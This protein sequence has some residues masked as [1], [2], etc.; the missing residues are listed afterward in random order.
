MWSSFFEQ[1]V[2]HTGGSAD[3]NSFLDAEDASRC[4]VTVRFGSPWFGK[5]G[6]F[7]GA[8]E[9]RSFH[10]RR[11]RHV[12]VTADAGTTHL[13]TVAS[14]AQV[15]SQLVHC[16]SHSDSSFILHSDGADAHDFQNA[17]LPP[18][19]VSLLPSR[20]ECLSCPLRALMFLLLLFCG[21]IGAVGRNSTLQYRMTVR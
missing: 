1:R 20:F 11:G 13:R 15:C 7:R 3:L 12:E 4:S 2:A 14:S 17:V 6:D 5:F 18:K 21:T 9:G 8:D 16:T 19:F 10:Q